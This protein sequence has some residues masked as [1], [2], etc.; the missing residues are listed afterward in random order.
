M[1]VELL[2]RVE[3]HILEEPKRLFMRKW[4]QFKR[5]YAE[6]NTAACIAGWAVMLTGDKKAVEAQ[7]KSE[8]SWVHQRSPI[9][10]A[11][12]E[13]LQLT[14]TE[15]YRLFDPSAWPL[16]F[17]HGL[18]DDGSRDSAEATVQR[19]EW[20]IHTEGRDQESEEA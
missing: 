15:S 20:F 3:A 6:C 14:P 1:N 10:E 4:V 13:L 17:Y 5:D 12:Q 19:I 11:A 16:Q 7:L 9:A 8:T 18:T 2:R